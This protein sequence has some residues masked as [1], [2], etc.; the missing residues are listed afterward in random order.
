MNQAL[1]AVLH[2]SFFLLGLFINPEDEGS[3]FP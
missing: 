1:L 3:M 2:A